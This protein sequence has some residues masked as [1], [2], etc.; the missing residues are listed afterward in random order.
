MVYIACPKCNEILEYGA[1][2][3]NKCEY[4][5]NEYTAN[6]PES[7]FNYTRMFL[8]ILSILLLFITW[9]AISNIKISMYT[10][11][12]KPSVTAKADAIAIYRKL[13]KTINQ[14]DRASADLIAT[15][16]SDDL[17]DAFYAAYAMQ[18]TCK[19]TYKAIQA[20]EIPTS[21]GRQVH[22]NLSRTVAICENEYRD[23][24][25]TASRLK[26]MINVCEP[27]VDRIASLRETITAT[28]DDTLLCTIGLAS[29]AK[30]A[31]ITQVDLAMQASK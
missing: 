24:A 12:D 13:I 22:E 25:Y 30:T 21:L 18:T 2:I 31:G 1:R 26:D 9:F 16:N 4:Y 6:I 17:G 28:S 23:R 3:C 27:S 14:C 20:L 19:S 11:P 29:T 10:V 5:C 8:F 7:N 15:A